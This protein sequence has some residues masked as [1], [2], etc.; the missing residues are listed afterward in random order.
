MG[1]DIRLNSVEAIFPACRR[2]EMEAVLAGQSWFEQIQ[3]LVGREYGRV[4]AWDAVNAPM[5]RQ[6]CEV[7][8]VENP[9][10]TDPTF[11]RRAGHADVLA[12]P[13]MLQ[14]WC[15][16]GLDMENYPPGS[17]DENSFE[18]LKIMES[19]GYPAVVAVNSELSFE[20]YPRVGEQL[21]YTSRLESISEEKSTA[22]GT[23][24][25]VTMMMPFY[26]ETSGGKDERVGELLFRVF[27]FKP[28]GRTDSQVK[29]RSA[30]MPARPSPIKRPLPGISDDTRFFWEGCEEGKL[31][32]QRCQ[33]CHTLRHP[34]APVCNQ[35]HSF[36]WD[37][38][39]AS[40]LGCLY[41]FVVMHY[42]QVPPFD[43]PNPVGLIELDE[44]VRL[45]AGLVG[46][47][48]EDFHIGQRLQVEFRRFDE[49]QTL[50]QFRPL[51]RERGTRR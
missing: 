20:R 6:W 26:V 19:H 34:P 42:P 4:R 14:V 23:G 22:L 46:A 2:W 7:M 9:L 28:A 15:M 12:P 38:I 33:D 36:R 51:V 31:R 25:F 41:S 30:S 17:T 45:V 44:G 10:Y 1:E 47:A 24:F 43:Y 49:Q 3:A 8:G 21:Y 40:G 13:A 48:S 35:C 32:I 11:A 50:P 5:I 16:A 27:K 39:E 29:E 18:V 37:S